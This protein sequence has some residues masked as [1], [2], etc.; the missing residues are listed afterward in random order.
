MDKIQHKFAQVNG[1][2]IHAAEIGGESSPA[3]VLLH[4]FPEIWYSWRHQMIAVAEAGFR[5]IAPDYRGYGLSDPPPEPDK[6]SFKD[7]VADLLSLLDALAIQKEFVIGKH[8]GAVVACLFARFHPQRVCGVITMGVPY[9]PI[10]TPISSTGPDHL[11]EG[12]YAARWQKPGRAEA[13]FGHFD[14]K[15]VVRN[16]YILFS[17]NLA[18]YGSLYENSGFQTALKVPYRSMS[19]T[20][21]ITNEKVEVPAL[22]IM[23]EKDYTQKIPGMEDYIKSD[24]VKAFVPKVETVFV[25]EGSHFVQEQFPH[26]VNHLILNF[27]Q[28]T[29]V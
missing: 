8:F 20:Y 3:V 19:E 9:L 21:N 10:S 26:Q 23:G 5:A 22:L 2:K 7:L 13:D 6:A 25:P 18:N 29:N 4:G 28:I 17:L 27:L 15:T 14:N 12:F 16:V 11:P 24:Q 1:L